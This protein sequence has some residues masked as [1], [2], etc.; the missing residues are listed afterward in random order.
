[1]KF[2]RRFQHI[3]KRAKEINKEL[4]EMTLEEMDVF[5]NEAKEKG[6]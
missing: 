6:F 2:T 4:R 5:W 1:M 3:E